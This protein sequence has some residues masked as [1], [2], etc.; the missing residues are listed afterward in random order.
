MESAHAAIS[1]S[2]KKLFGVKK[3]LL[4]N[5]EEQEED[6]IK[7]NDLILFQESFNSSFANFRNDI[8]LELFEFKKVIDLIPELKGTIEKLT[9]DNKNL[10]DGMADL[11]GELL[12]SEEQRKKEKTRAEQI[13]KEMKSLKRSSI[14]SDMMNN[15]VESIKSEI[16][17]QNQTIDEL[18][19]RI[20]EIPEVK[21]VTENN[22][23]WENKLCQLELDIETLKTNS[24]PLHYH[25]KKQT[26][27]VKPDEYKINEEFLILGDSNTKNIDVNKL[28]RFGETKKIFCPLFD[29]IVEAC[30]KF[31]IIKQPSKI[32]VHCGTNDLDKMDP[33]E[34]TNKIDATIQKLHE[35][36][37]A[38]TILISSLIPRRLDTFDEAIGEINKYIISLSARMNFINIM[39]NKK[40]YKKML[41]D[42]KHLNKDVFFVFLTN[43]KFVLFGEIPYIL[44][45]HNNN[46]NN[47]KR[48]GNHR[49]SNNNNHRI[50]RLQ[51]NSN[52]YTS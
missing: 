31:N 23:E 36:F 34:I 30:D 44:R 52:S 3:N 18:T 20:K 51:S 16:S 48:S 26:N 29:S 15:E 28:K 45:S 1:P 38:S 11:K 7:K 2:I 13:F 9:I 33:L 19:R 12:I 25:K 47:F 40:I 21:I 5:A 8:Q 4:F 27:V 32:F 41:C 43:I 50:H 37:P 6:A 49:S 46:N 14:T 24:S 42:D 10:K 22:K 17:T 35:K 39:N